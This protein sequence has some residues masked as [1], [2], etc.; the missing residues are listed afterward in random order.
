MTRSTKLAT[1]ALSV[2]CGP[3][4][5]CWIVFAS[6]CCPAR[7]RPQRGS[8]DKRRFEKR[9]IMAPRPLPVRSP[10]RALTIRKHAKQHISD[11]HDGTLPEEPRGV[12]REQSASILLRLPLELRELIYRAA[13]GDSVMHVVLKKYKLGHIR[14]KAAK[15]Y[16]LECDR[17]CTR[18]IWRPF[19]DLPEDPPPTD[20][21]I[22]PLLLTCR[23]V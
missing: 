19:A 1:I 14:C 5:C 12:V 22:L 7:L 4:L 8:E 21:N 16:P 2:V 17:L 6:C 9:Q 23:Q 20:S 10:K 13:V 15:T 11:E 18:Y 3:V